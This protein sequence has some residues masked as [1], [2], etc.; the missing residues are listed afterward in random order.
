MPVE[1]QNN[2]SS[3]EKQALEELKA[4]TKTSI[5]IKKADKTDM[6]VIMGKTE[7]RDLV[8]KQHLDTPTYE[9]ADMD[10]NKKVFANLQTLI[11]ANNDCLTKGER[12]FIL[13]EDWTNAFFYV[14]CHGSSPIA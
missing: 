6:W 9:G 7:Y 11:E 8:L 13:K 3:R 2:I 5:E 12:K 4:L 10:V 1:S 14:L